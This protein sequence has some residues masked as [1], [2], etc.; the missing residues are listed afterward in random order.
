V[1]RP[2]AWW[3]ADGHI[4]QRQVRHPDGSV[5]SG[6]FK[7]DQPDGIGKIT[8]TTIKPYGAWLLVI[9]GNGRATHA[10]GQSGEGDFVAGQYTGTGVI[11]YL[12]GFAM[13]A[14][15]KMACATASCVATAQNIKAPIMG[16]FVA[17]TRAKAR[18]RS[19]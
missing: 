16:T 7:D 18:A 9:E 12:D 1:R 2:P 3:L 4:K 5:Y 10:T 8:Q 11:T 14:H 6:S 13:K 19:H 15:G 17:G